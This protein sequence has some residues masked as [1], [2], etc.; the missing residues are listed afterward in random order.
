MPPGL[1]SARQRR[2][3]RAGRGSSWITYPARTTPKVPAANGG[4]SASPRVTVMVPSPHA[5]AWAAVA[6]S[7][8]AAR[9]MACT[10]PLVPGQPG[11]RDGHCSLAAA[12]VQHVRARPDARLASQAGAHVLEELGAALVIAA[13]G[14]GE[15]GDH[16]ILDGSRQSV[17]CAHREVISRASSVTFTD[18][19]RACCSRIRSR[20]GPAPPR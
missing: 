3:A 15:P 16:L 4:S 17:R 12:H 10:R 8:G 5:R 7:I 18:E 2:A 19:G 20:P 13:G 1:S 11:G 9:S 14:L 6:S